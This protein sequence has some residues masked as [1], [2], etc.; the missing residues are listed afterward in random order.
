[1]RSTEQ[2]AKPNT[3]TVSQDSGWLGGALSSPILWGTALTVGFYALVPHMPVQ[4]EL[5]VRYFCGHPLEYVTAALFFLGLATLGRKLARQAAERSALASG[6][7]DAPALTEQTDPL[8]RAAVLDERLAAAP[9]RSRR[10]FFAARLAD[11]CAYVRGRRSTAGL[12]EHLKYLAELAASRLYDSYATVRTITWAVPIVGFLGTVIGITLAIANITVDPD[13][14]ESSFLEVTGGLA[15][16]FDTTALALALSLVLVFASFFVERGEQSVLADVEDLG[17]Q[18]ILTLFPETAPQS[19]TDPLLRAESQAAER[20]IER[21]DALVERQMRLWEES[22]EAT[23]SRWLDTLARQQQAFDESLHKGMAATLSDH[24]GQLAEGRT[25][26]LDALA[27][28]SNDLAENLGGAR[29][30]AREML[31]ELRRQGEILLQI[32]GEEQQL[33]RLEGRLAENLDAIRAVER[34]DETLHSLNAAVHLLT[35]R[36]TGLRKAA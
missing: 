16:A 21:T 31:V 36:T 25:Q 2:L 15:V 29:E 9:P 6:L 13:Q 19:A 30:S 8:H 4:R 20:L 26:F 22:L 12:E 32:V 7:L 28:V 33:V 14:L 1:M 24:G 11:V 35:A 23:R 17:I 3:R 5:L 18:R 34:F 10:T 27:A